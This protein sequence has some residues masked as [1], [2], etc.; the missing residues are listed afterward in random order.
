MTQLVGSGFKDERLLQALVCILFYTHKLS[1]HVSPRLSL[2]GTQITY[3]AVSALLTI[4]PSR[5]LNTANEF[6]L[7]SG[8]KCGI[9]IVEITQKAEHGL[10]LRSHRHR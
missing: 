8:R 2:S 9:S 7:L 1:S 4:N 5:I 10:S 6:V 3:A